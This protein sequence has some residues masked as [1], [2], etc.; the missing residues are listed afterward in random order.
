MIEKMKKKE[1]IKLFFDL[2]ILTIL[3]IPMIYEPY[4]FFVQQNDRSVGALLLLLFVEM[5]FSIIA[6]IFFF[7]MIWMPLR[8]I[9]KRVH[10]PWDRDNMGIFLVNSEGKTVDDEL[11]D[12]FRQKKNNKK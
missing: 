3:I 2:I 9:K 11:K 10:R 5:M 7:M 6:F 8:L 12:L 4:A 1:I